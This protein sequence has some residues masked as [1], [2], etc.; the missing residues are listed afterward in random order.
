MCILAFRSF[1]FFI[2]RDQQRE[3]PGKGEERGSLLTDWGCQAGA[4]PKASELVVETLQF[5]YTCLYELPRWAPGVLGVTHR[6]QLW[7][8]MCLYFHNIG[9]HAGQTRECLKE[10][11]SLSFSAATPYLGPSEHTA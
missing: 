2:S 10:A 3:V 5:L 1:S 11:Q 8:Q 4:Y 9:D 6:E 7:N